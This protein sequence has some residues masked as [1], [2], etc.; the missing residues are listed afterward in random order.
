VSRINAESCFME[1]IARN[2]PTV[3]SRG[4]QTFSTYLDE[5]TYPG[6]DQSAGIGLARQPHPPQPQVP[7]ATSVSL[8]LS[9]ARIRNEAV[10]REVTAEVAAAVRGAVMGALTAAGCGII[11]PGMGHF[12]TTDPNDL[13]RLR[14]LRKVLAHCDFHSVPLPEI[15]AAFSVI[16]D[17]ETHW[18]SILHPPGPALVPADAEDDLADITYVDA[19]Y[20]PRRRNYLQIE[21]KIDPYA[22]RA[23]PVYTDAD[24]E[25]WGP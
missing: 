22:R 10:H 12:N 15:S 13:D 16:R 21:L 7:H 4:P 2:D 20:P 3:D 17:A 25:T 9:D 11:Q 19:D 24:A 18:L 5:L 14:H 6:E 1:T 23:K 8:W